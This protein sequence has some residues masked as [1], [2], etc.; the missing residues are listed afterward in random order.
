MSDGMRDLLALTLISPL[1][2]WFA[3][4]KCRFKGQFGSRG[5]KMGP[6]GKK[7]SSQSTGMDSC[8]CQIKLDFVI[9][10]VPLA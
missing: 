5:E 1:P 10:Q 2:Y 9:A 8:H 3:G 6:W 7:G 4:R